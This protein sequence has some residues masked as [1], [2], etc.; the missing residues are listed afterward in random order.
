M[1]LSVDVEFDYFVVEARTAV[2]APTFVS[3]ETAPVVE[4]AAWAAAGAVDVAVVEPDDVS[5][6]LRP[7]PDDGVWLELPPRPDVSGLPGA[8]CGPPVVAFALPGA[9]E[10]PGVASELLAGAV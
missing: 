6:E 4:A 8:V 2:V 1:L 5:L 3:V 9:V 7:P 10:L